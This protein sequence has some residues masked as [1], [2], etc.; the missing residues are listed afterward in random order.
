MERKEKELWRESDVSVRGKKQW[1]PMVSSRMSSTLIQGG[2]NTA[3]YLTYAALPSLVNGALHG[4]EPSSLGPFGEGIVFGTISVA[5]VG[6]GGFL[7]WA[8][9]RRCCSRFMFHQTKKNESLALVN[10]S[11]VNYSEA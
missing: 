10:H 8:C 1:A 2:K 7:C 6:T 9:Y 3:Q 11:E 5:I 4:V